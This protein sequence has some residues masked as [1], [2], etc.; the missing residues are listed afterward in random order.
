M[1]FWDFIFALIEIFG[2]YALATI[3]F[4]LVIYFLG[5][6]AWDY[7][8][9]SKIEIERS[10]LDLLKNNKGNVFN[11][12]HERKL[13]AY[14]DL[15]SKMVLTYQKFNEYV[16]PVKIVP[17]NMTYEDFCVE[18]QKEFIEMY[19]S[20]KI[21]YHNSLI[22]IPSEIGE[23]I[24]SIFE[25][26]NELSRDYQEY[27]FY[28]LHGVRDPNKLDTALKKQLDASKFIKSEFPKFIDDIVTV[29]RQ[30]ILKHD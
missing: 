4:G 24:K 7:F 23:K 17:K 21:S 13:D 19:R 3:L 16:D 1:T 30:D 12:L 28:T 25:K 8:I 2:T 11:R 18:K 9:S 27:E 20:L 6:K 14:T 26:F 22:L 5:P 15:F 29:F 10:N